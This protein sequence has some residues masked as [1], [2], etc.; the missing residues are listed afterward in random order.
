M[1]LT[2][3][4]PTII[5][6][7]ICLMLVTYNNKFGALSRLLRDL[8]K[9]EQT[10]SSQRQIQKI[11]KRLLY[12]QMMEL[13]GVIGLMLSLMSAFCLAFGYN[14]LGSWIFIAS[15]MSV[16]ISLSLAL[17]EILLSR[18]ALKELCNK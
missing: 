3:T 7:T 17:V 10:P 14:D 11:R 18:N 1:L 8:S 9:N 13:F 16:F 6:P 15:V 4:A 5:A 2:V 12:I